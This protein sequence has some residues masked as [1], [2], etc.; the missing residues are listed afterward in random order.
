MNKIY[1]FLSVLL[2]CCVYS[3]DDNDQNK[4]KSDCPSLMQEN[5]EGQY[6]NDY[7]IIN[8]VSSQDNELNLNISHSGG[9]E[10]HEYELIQEPLFCGTPPIYISIYLSHNSNN[11]PCE[12]WITED[13]CFDLSTVFENFP[14]DDITIGLYNTHQSDTTWIIAP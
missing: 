1:Y 6:P 4:P 12:A 11:D 9:C 14:E 8:S 2:A 13:L 10:D 7:L 3:C 5:N